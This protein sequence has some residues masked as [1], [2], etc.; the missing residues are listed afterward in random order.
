MPREKE[1][2]VGDESAWFFHDELGMTIVLAVFVSIEQDRHAQLS[3]ERDGT[4]TS[5]FEGQWSPKTSVAQK[6]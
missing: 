3:V 4:R 2:S 5:H 6:V 1:S